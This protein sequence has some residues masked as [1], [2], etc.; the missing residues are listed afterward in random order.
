MPGIDPLLLINKGKLT[1]SDLGLLNKYS[2]VF[3]DK[4]NS[5]IYVDN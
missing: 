4:F 3:K 1:R 2:N 5:W